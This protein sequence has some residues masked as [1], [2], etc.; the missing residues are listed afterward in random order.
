MVFSML[1]SLYVNMIIYIRRIRRFVTKH[2]A[3][4]AYIWGSMYY[5]CV[6]FLGVSGMCTEYCSNVEY[7]R[8]WLRCVKWKGW[9]GELER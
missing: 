3:V 8:G 7:F 5:A 6:N 4:G 1:T 9:G 2:D